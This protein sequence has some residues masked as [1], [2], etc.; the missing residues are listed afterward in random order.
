MDIK[1]FRQKLLQN[2]KIKERSFKR[3]LAYQIGKMVI[4]SRIIKGLTQEELAKRIGT[5]QASIA[6]LERGKS[7]PSL[8]FL[9]KIAGAYNSY[10]IAPKFAFMEE[11][12]AIHYEV[13]EWLSDTMTF[14][15]VTPL[16]ENETSPRVTLKALESGR[17]MTSI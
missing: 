1:T 8:T 7:L 13:P 9:D 4:E 16:K 6:R 10:L 2:K 5:K 11:I 14:N 3:D 12:R 17:L 15:S